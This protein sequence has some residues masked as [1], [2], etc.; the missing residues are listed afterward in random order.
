[1]SNKDKEKEIRRDSGLSNTL[2]S[3]N[4]VNNRDETIDRKV[5]NSH[6]NGVS[7]YLKDKVIG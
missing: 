4:Q 1:M 6:G 2:G 5:K 7:I 3:Q